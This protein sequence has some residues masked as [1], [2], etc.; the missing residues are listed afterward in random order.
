MDRR[1]FLAGAAA[2]AATAGA[3]EAGMNGRSLALLGRS[4]K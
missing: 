4:Y 3:A 2:L 1:E